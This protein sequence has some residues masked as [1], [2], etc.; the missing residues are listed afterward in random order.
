[1]NW[2]RRK[3]P[4]HPV[5]TKGGDEASRMFWG[6]PTRCPRCLGAGFLDS[7]NLHKRTME[8]HCP[9]CGHRWVTSEA[10]IAESRTH[11]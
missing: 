8:Q 7:I 2:F 3:K 6:K 9:S 10:E 1:M 11:A 4:G 5:V